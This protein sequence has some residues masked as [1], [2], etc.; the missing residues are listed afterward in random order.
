MLSTYDY[1]YYLLHP[2]DL[3]HSSDLAHLDYKHSLER[4]DISLEDKLKR[5]NNSFEEIYQSKRKILT[6]KQLAEIQL[7]NFNTPN[8]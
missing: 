3:I 8:I 1:F 5:L 2:A 6:M 7:H 4:I